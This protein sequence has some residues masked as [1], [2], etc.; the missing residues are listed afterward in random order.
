MRCT[1]PMPWIPRN[2]EVKRLR[3]RLDSLDTETPR[4]FRALRDGDY[5]G[6]R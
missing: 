5:R 6:T 2:R 1:T 3:E 4:R